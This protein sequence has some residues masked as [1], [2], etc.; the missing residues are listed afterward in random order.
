MVMDNWQKTKI[1]YEYLAD[2]AGWM[3]SIIMGLVFAFGF[4]TLIF[5][6][7]RERESAWRILTEAGRIFLRCL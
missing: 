3:G 7:S 5:A 6:F 1:F 2:L 4:V